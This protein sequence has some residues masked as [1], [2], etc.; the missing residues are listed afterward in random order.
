MR[1]IITR[2]GNFFREYAE[3]GNTVMSVFAL[4]VS[5][6]FYAIASLL[7]H[8]CPQ[9]LA[10]AV[11]FFINAWGMP[12]LAAVAGFMLSRFFLHTSVDFS[13]FLGIYAWAAS[14]VLLAGW[15]PYLV[16]FT[17]VWRWW[18]IGVGLIG[19][20]GIKRWQAVM[21]VA[22]TLALMIGGYGFLTSQW[23]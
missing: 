18:L 10:A 7:M 15:I 14:A 5:S 13:K 16:L 11:I 9:P 8:T 4:S 19:V 6:I 3:A 21:V 2:P 23:L 20:C 1:R 22:A 12:L 17:E